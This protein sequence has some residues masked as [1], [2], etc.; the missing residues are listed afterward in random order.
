MQEIQ[1]KKNGKDVWLLNRHFGDLNP[2][3]LGEE[4]CR[5]GKSFG[6]SVRKYTLIHAVFSGCGC[7]YKGDQVYSVHAG[8]AFII[9]PDEVVTYVADEKTPWHYHWIAFDGA[10]SYR[11]AELPT[12][13]QFPLNIVKEMIELEDKGV[14][15]YRLAGYLFQIYAYLFEKQKPNTH[16]VRRV[17]DYIRSLYMNP[18]RVEEIAA[19]LNLDRRYLSRIFKQ[20][21][22]QTIQDFL[23]SV[24]MEEA[25][26]LL[27]QG[28]TVE[29]AAL[30]SGYE[31]AC[32]FS[33]MFKRRF[34]VSPQYWKEEHLL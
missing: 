22:G 16:Y 25:K 14:K 5:P 21:T 13:V 29:Q 26:R 15:E 34:G 30:L 11:F 9:N 2:L 6:P 17:Q 4:I 20:K 33:K 7:V 32:N 23:I 24:R 8:E 12:V 10:L 27:S 31:D 28:S 1:N 3:F 18:L 19:Q